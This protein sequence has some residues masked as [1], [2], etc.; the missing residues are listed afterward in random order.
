MTGITFIVTKGNKAYDMTQLVQSIRWS[1][2]KSAMPRTLEVT[3]LDSDGHGHTRP[4]INIESGHQCLFRWNGTELFRGIFFTSSQTVSR[5]ATYKA[6]DTGIYLAKNIDTFVYKK[7]TATEIFI[8]I[9]KHF[10]L[11]YSS[12]DTDYVIG[13]LTMPNTTA[14]DAIWKALAKTYKAK[15]TRYYVLS[16]NGVLKLISRAD[17]VVQLVLEEG[18]NAI[19]FT[20]EVSIE[21]TYTRVKLYSDAN[22]LLASASDTSIEANIGVMQYAEQGDSEKKKAALDSKAKNLLSIKKQTEETLEVELIGDATVYSGVAVYVNLPY[23][24]ITKTYYVDEDEHEFIGS[25]HTM[26]LK[27]NATNDVEGADEDDDDD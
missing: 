14:A 17:N 5:T 2:A 11:E 24:G 22:K 4:G 3:M 6:Y 15:G 16:Q 23:L 20:R 18:A 25:K 19:D 8:A 13:D 21:N 12:V 7:K 27:L 1:G 9:C 26:R 10:G